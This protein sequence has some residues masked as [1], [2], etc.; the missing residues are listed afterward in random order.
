MNQRNSL[1]MGLLMSTGKFSIWNWLIREGIRYRDS[2]KVMNLQHL[3]LA[4][5]KIHCPVDYAWISRKYKGWRWSW[6]LN[7]LVNKR[8]NSMRKML[9]HLPWVSIDLQVLI[10]LFLKFWKRRSWKLVV[11]WCWVVLWNNWRFR[12]DRLMNLLSI[13]RFKFWWMKF[14]FIV[15]MLSKRVVLKEFISF[16]L[17]RI[18]IPRIY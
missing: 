13:I 17:K 2:V 14:Y 18:R 6:C 16:M 3:F 9:L 1:F 12:V 5:L 8:N 4:K 11:S 15:L 10:D 7:I